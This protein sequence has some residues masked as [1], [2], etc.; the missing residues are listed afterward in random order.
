MFLD[1][2]SWFVEL[3]MICTERSTQ[4]CFVVP[5][6]SVV[7]RVAPRYVWDDSRDDNERSILDGRD[8]I[9]LRRFQRKEIQRETLT[10]S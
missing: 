3:L 4:A 6:L 7:T 5:T 8:V 9:I 1:S 10:S 2:F